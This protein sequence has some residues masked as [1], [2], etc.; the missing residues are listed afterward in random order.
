ML[1]K[2][3]LKQNNISQSAF[4]EKIG[5][6]DSYISQLCNKDHPMNCSLAVARTIE[7]ITGGCVCLADLIKPQ[8]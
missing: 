8:N 7:K 4:A 3:W 5:K 2:D 1:L 6:G